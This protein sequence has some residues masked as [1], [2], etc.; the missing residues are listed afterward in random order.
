[1]KTPT[2]VHVIHHASSSRPT[3][4]SSTSR[5][6]NCLACLGV[7]AIVSRSLF[8]FQ[9]LPLLFFSRI[10]S[11]ADDNSESAAAEIDLVWHFQRIERR[12][13]GDEY[14]G[15]CFNGYEKYKFR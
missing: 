7:I 6:G 12:K 9:R 1:L 13:F 14:Q 4:L 8:I 10:E 15:R 2:C 5:G 3:T 11:R